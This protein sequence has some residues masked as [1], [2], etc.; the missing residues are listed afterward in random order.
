[1]N[2]EQRRISEKEG[3]RLQKL[4]WNEFVDVTQ[5]IQAIARSNMFK[6][7]A[8]LAYKNNRY[9]VQV[10]LK[11]KRKGVMYTRVMVRRNDSLPIC[12]W[13]D[14]YRIKNELFG[15]ETEAVQFLPPKSEL[16][17]AANLYWFFI[18]HKEGEK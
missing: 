3:R 1:M 16:I 6:R 5:E 12:S 14:M 18:P 7:P 17:D 11:V 8:D 15:E 2:R 10:F 13:S 4:H 9:V